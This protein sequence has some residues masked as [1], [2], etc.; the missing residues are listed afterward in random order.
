MI[1]HFF[2]VCFQIKLYQVSLYGE[3]QVCYEA[4]FYG[5]LKRM[6]PHYDTYRIGI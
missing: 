2:L 4:C 6:L 3:C 1:V 5:Y